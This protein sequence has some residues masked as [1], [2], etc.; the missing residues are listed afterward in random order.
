MRKIT[1]SKFLKEN[2]ILN[3]SIIS[4]CIV[5]NTIAIVTKGNH[6]LPKYGTGEVTTSYI[7]LD[8][9]TFL[10][11][12]LAIPKKYFNTLIV[13]VFN[14]SYTDVDGSLHN[15]LCKRVYVPKYIINKLLHQ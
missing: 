13:K 8:K 5:N 6:Y 11:T 9:Y 3:R 10:P 7:K 12:G 1:F 2:N 14:T 4:C 15:T